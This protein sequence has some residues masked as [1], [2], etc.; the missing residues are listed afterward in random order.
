MF[1][2]LKYLVGYIAGTT[3]YRLHYKPMPLNNNKTL[4]LHTM[5]N[6]TF[7]CTDFGRSWYGY[8]SFLNN[9]PW[10][11]KSCISLSV[12]CSPPMAE[13]IACFQ[14]LNTT[15]WGIQLLKHIQQPTSLPIPMHTDSQ[16]MMKIMHKPHIT[17]Q[18]RHFPPKFF[19]I[20]E[21]QIENTIR[22]QYLSTD[23]LDANALT[24][25]LGPTKFFKHRLSIGITQ[26][27][28]A[29]HQKKDL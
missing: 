29:N 4:Q 6:A 28:N 25:S 27:T 7:N 9:S 5:S 16:T 20:M 14:A 21:H 11:W 17:N 1:N 24:K 15:L 13:T 26:I 3:N 19:K 22:L 12:P 10:S 23:E 8:I 18:A 2:M